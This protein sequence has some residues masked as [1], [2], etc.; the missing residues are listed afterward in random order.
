MSNLIEFDLKNKPQMGR[1]SLNFSFS[2]P[3]PPAVMPSMSF[4]EL[5]P[6]PNLNQISAQPN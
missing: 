6:I 1:P 2:V 5:L 3:K 4:P